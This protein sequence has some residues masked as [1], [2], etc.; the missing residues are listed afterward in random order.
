MRRD[1]LKTVEVTY[2]LVPFLILLIGFS[3]LTGFTVK[4]RVE[5]KHDLLE[6]RTIEIANSY[7]HNLTH[8]AEA[9]DRITALLDDKFRIVAQALMRIEDKDNSEVLKD[10]AKT[11]AVDEISVYNSDGKI[12]SST[13]DQL[14]GWEVYEG[15]PV[16]DFMVSNQTVRIEK[17][18]QDT[19]NGLYY[20]FGYMRDEAGGFIQVGILADNIQDFLEDFEIAKLINEISQRDDVKSVFFVNTKFEI[21]AS[22]LTNYA[23]TTIEDQVLQRKLISE[24][25]YAERTEMDDKEIFRVAVPIYS[26]FMR[27]GTLV[28]DWP[29]DNLDAQVLE[30]I[31]FGAIVLAVIVLT[32]GSILYYAYR[33][34]QAN[35]K[36][37]YYDELTGLRNNKYL[38]DYLDHI[39]AVPRRR[40]KAVLL[41]HVK[42]LKTVNMT[43]GFEYG[44]A[45]VKQ[46]AD[47]IRQELKTDDNFFR[48]DG[49]QFVV[50]SD[51][52]E[53]QEELRKLAERLICIFDEPVAEGTDLQYVDI[54][55]A[56]VEIQARHTSTDKILQD[57]LLALTHIEDNAAHPIVF[58]NEQME[59]SL[60][61]EDKIMKVLRDV[62]DGKGK[63]SFY[64]EYQPKLDLNLNR[65]ISFE[66]L[67]RLHIDQLGQIPP[68]EFIDLAEKNLLINELG[69]HILLLAADFLGRMYAQG[70]DDITLAVNISGVQ[71]LREDFVEYLQNSPYLNDQI[72]QA[73]EFEITE[74]VLLEH[75]DKINETLE[76]IKRLGIAVS[77]DD[78][79]TGFSSLSRIGELHIDTV[80][81]DRFL[82]NAFLIC[83]T[84]I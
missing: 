80:K 26:D 41:L 47:K 84:R 4:N 81:I 42:N 33:K 6:E 50:V 32:T 34:N 18:R 21:V 74:S 53:G 58:F 28:I 5:E 69:N 83:R 20:K 62:V 3:V 55:I 73:I 13:H 25:A 40:N 29:T 46:I 48:F 59:K 67:A 16:Y 52:V 45:L 35:I 79:G 14:L 39:V 56:I 15:H 9:Y 54:Q 17:I 38:H 76:Q 2:F 61:R 30:I 31:R 24:Q 82:S 44:D 70:I 43:Y 60:Q 7:S 51:S 12:V 27:T 11:F 77:L 65:V 23:G 68:D 8:T 1:K 63:T 19:E 78:F 57:A 37:A 22:S 36:I 71:L 10:I 66:A 64:L 72:M 49:N 75:Y